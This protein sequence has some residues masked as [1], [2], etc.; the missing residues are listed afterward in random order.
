MPKPVRGRRRDIETVCA[1]CLAEP[2]MLI[3]GKTNSTKSLDAV[4]ASIFVLG[5]PVV[6]LPMV[7][8][9]DM[10]ASPI[11]VVPSSPTMPG[12][13]IPAW[14]FAKRILPQRPTAAGQFPLPAPRDWHDAEEEQ[15]EFLAPDHFRKEITALA[16]AVD[17]VLAEE[18]RG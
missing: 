9:N 2:E 4:A 18:F 15:F 11:D 1:G 10:R 8:V 16:R 17:C 13:E 5:S 14:A 3:A 12:A 6:P 7:D